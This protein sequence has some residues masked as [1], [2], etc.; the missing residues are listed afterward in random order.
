MDA[1]PM[2]T[3]ESPHGAPEKRGLLHDVVVSSVQPAALT[4]MGRGGVEKRPLHVV[5]A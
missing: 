3:I 1:M 2:Q 5:F 4:A